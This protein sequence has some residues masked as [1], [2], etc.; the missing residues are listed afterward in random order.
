MAGLC[1]CVEVS[2][3]C[4]G[5]P[6]EREKEDGVQRSVCGC[7]KLM[8]RPEREMAVSRRTVVIRGD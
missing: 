3:G 5:V 8:S 4:G 6:L 1:V 7:A 2:R